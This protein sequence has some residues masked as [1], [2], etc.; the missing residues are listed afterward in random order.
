MWTHTGPGWQD[1]KRIN[2]VWTRLFQTSVKYV[3][4]L[5]DARGHRRRKT[6]REACQRIPYSDSL[7][8]LL[9]SPWVRAGPLCRQRFFPRAQASIHTIS[10]HTSGKKK[11]TKH[12]TGRKGEGRTCAI[13]SSTQENAESC[14]VMVGKRLRDQGSTRRGGWVNWQSHE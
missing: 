2:R 14:W 6:P 9:S 10:S 3:L 7:Y 8:F 12:L 13:V 1:D 11:K 5:D 4:L